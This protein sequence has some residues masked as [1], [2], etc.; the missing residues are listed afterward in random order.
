MIRKTK[1]RSVEYSEEFTP[2]PS[3]LGF[4]VLIFSSPVHLH[5]VIHKTG[6]LLNSATC[7]IA[8]GDETILGTQL[9][10]CDLKAGL[11]EPAWVILS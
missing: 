4:S 8:T 6:A 10:S 1:H 11:F 2:L 7:E 5:S 3:F 9:Y